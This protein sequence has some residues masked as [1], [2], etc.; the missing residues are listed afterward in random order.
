M[1]K[2]INFSAKKLV[3]WFLA[4]SIGVIFFGAT[5]FAGTTP[6]ITSATFRAT[7]T[8]TD[9]I[10]VKFNMPVFATANGTGN[11]AADCS[12][13]TF[14]DAN[15]L[16]LLNLTVATCTHVAGNDWAL[17]ELADAQVAVAGDATG[18]TIAAAAN[19]IFSVG[20]ALST[21]TTPLVEDTTA[22]TYTAV[23]YKSGDDKLLVTFSEPVWT[24]DYKGTTAFGNAAVANADFSFTNGNAAGATALAAGD[25]TPYHIGDRDKVILDLDA[26]LI[27]GDIDGTGTA[28]LFDAFNVASTIFDA[29]GNG[30]A[31]A[32]KRLGAAGA[33]TPDSTVPTISTVEAV[34]G[35]PRILVNFSEPVFGATGTL[36]TLDNTTITND[37]TYADTGGAKTVGAA[38]AV[39]HI[40]GNEW[41]LLTLSGNVVEADITTATQDT[42]TP[43]A[44]AIYD[45]FANAAAATAYG[46]NDTTDPVLLSVAP[47]NAGAANKNIVTLTY[48]EGV[49]ITG[50]PAAGASQASTTTIGDMTTALT[51]PGFGTF[52]AGNA[53]FTT[54]K[55]TVARN[56]TSTVYTITL[57][58]QDDLSFR[59][60]PAAGTNTTALSGNFTPQ[61]DEAG[62]GLEVAD[63]DADAANKIEAT[64]IVGTTTSTWDITTPVWVGGASGLAYASQTTTTA[65][66]GWTAIEADTTFKRY[67]V[68]Y[69]TT[70]GTTYANGTAWTTAGDSA[71]STITTASTTITGLNSGTTYYITMYAIDASGSPSAVAAEINI[72]TNSSAGSADGT[73][74]AAPTSVAVKSED[75]KAVLTWVDPTATDLKDI[76]ILRGKGIF[77]VSGDA[78]AVA[79]KAVKTYTDSDVVVGDTVKYILRGRDTSNNQSAN[80]TEVSVTIVAAA[81][82]P[83]VTTPPV[84]ETPPAVEEPPAETPQLTEAQVKLQGKIDK[85]DVKIGKMQTKIDALKAK[86]KLTKAKKKQLKA[87]KKL[88]KKYQAQKVKFEAQLAE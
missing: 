28:D 56:T 32:A 15:S 46:L 53:T 77:P 50:G 9:K 45:A 13:F 18:D 33:N 4:V 11:L 47:T 80:S 30:V 84:T 29:F 6:A 17:L 41:L 7:G 67:E 52:G 64:S 23:A 66:I 78:Y 74:P 16:G 26:D 22:P 59:T 14:T 24:T 85:L 88:L 2:H 51:L 38:P 63:L 19:S 36:G 73:P 21:K 61:A 87:F 5:A 37:L 34:V 70:T 68:Y 60:A 69:R 10:L 81:E 71:L 72:Q 8:A 48:S 25:G 40:G 54:L 43:A 12:D 83:E 31:T 65:T 57:L 58:G 75:G 55:N 86:K 44:T 1:T 49:A 76:V 27:A 79:L 62:A 3:F 82:T 20:G 42:I 39:N 35:Q